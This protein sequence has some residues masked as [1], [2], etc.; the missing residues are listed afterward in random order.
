[1]LSERMVEM[2]YIDS[3][4]HPMVGTVL[5]RNSLKPHLVK[6]WY[7]SQEQSATFTAC[8]ENVLGVYSSP[9][10]EDCPV[11]CMDEKPLQ[12][13]AEARRGHRK[14]TVPLFRITNTYTVGYI[15]LH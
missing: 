15:F 8:M 4:S 3:I 7:V 13:L 14:V 9:C 10:D 5:K 12:L 1:M 11:V 6:E 2:G